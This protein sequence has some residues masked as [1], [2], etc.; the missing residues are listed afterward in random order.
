MNE[1][2]KLD[3]RVLIN[4]TSTSVLKKVY[5][6]INDGY[7]QSLVNCELIG[8]EMTKID[9]SIKAKQ[10]TFLDNIFNCAEGTK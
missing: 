10:F 6:K 3:L 4:A 9:K 2:E 8:R 5:G 1:A 7:I